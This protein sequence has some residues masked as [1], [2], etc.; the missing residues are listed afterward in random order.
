ML[1]SKIIV[2]IILK[3]YWENSP[4]EDLPIVIY[5]WYSCSLFNPESLNL[6]NR[7]QF[8]YCNYQNA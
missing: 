3:T 8:K 4:G 2:K 7:H 5:V 6:S 1:V